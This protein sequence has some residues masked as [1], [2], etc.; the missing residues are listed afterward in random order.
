[1]TDYE[2][3]PYGSLIELTAK[4]MKQRL[5]RKFNSLDLGITVDQWLIL[6]VLL[7]ADG[8]SQFT[9]AQKTYK[10]APTVT[11]IIDLLEKKALIERRTHADDRRKYNIYL[12]EKGREKAERVFPLVQTYRKQGWEGLQKEDYEKLKHILTT[13]QK[14]FAV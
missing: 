1:M 11:R 5:Q 13:I 6:D 12:S 2:Y 4:I 8:V 14:N 3:Q 9:I 7:H 10:D